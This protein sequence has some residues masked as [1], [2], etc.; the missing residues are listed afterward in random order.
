M[1]VLAAASVAVAEET[2]AQHEM[3]AYIQ[4]G[5]TKFSTPD[6]KYS[7]RVGARADIDGAI[8]FDD[9]TDRGN[10]ATLSAARIRLFSKLGDHFDFKFDVDFMAKGNIKTC[11]CAGIPIKTDSCVWVTSQSRSRPRTFSRQWIIRSLQS[12][13]LCRHSEPGVRSV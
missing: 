8:Y 11:L 4:D 2:E 12:R 1:C 13:R 6:G 9:H 10:G 7:F 5:I 3:N